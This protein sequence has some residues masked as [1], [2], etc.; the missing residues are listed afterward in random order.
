MLEKPL[1][2]YINQRELWAHLK[3][4]YGVYLS[5]LLS[6]IVISIVH[7]TLFMNSYKRDATPLLFIE[8]FLILCVYSVIV[9]LYENRFDKRVEEFYKQEEQAPIVFTSSTDKFEYLGLLDMAIHDHYYMLPFRMFLLAGSVGL[10]L[11]FV[12]H[13]LPHSIYW[14]ILSMI[15]LI[16]IG[17]PLT[18]L[19]WN[20]E[21]NYKFRNSGEHSF[22]PSSG[23]KSY[24]Y[25]DVVR[26]ETGMEKSSV[27]SPIEIDLT[28]TFAC[29]KSFTISNTEREY[30]TVV[31]NIERALAPRVSIQKLLTTAERQHPWLIDTYDKQVLFDLREVEEGS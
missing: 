31:Q 17:Y 21:S 18:K 14:L 4:N 12:G 8:S 25:K 13:N 9:R 19:F 22:T 11:L 16:F 10:L 27:V 2:Y 26:I 6:P 15:S 30:F 1:G 23:E 20:C 28:I 29:G 5:L 3:R 7:L 24:N